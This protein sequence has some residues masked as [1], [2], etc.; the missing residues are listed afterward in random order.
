[1]RTLL[2]YDK[3]TGIVLKEARKIVRRNEEVLNWTKL[4]EKY[5]KLSSMR[6]PV[7]EQIMSS[8]M[9]IIWTYAFWSRSSRFP[10]QYAD[11][12]P[13]SDVV[14][15][16]VQIRNSSKD[17]VSYSSTLFTSQS[18]ISTNVDIQMDDNKENIYPS[19]EIQKDFTSKSEMKAKPKMNLAEHLK[20][21][22]TEYEETEK[23]LKKRRI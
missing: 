7:W 8:M 13:S 5:A 21:A 2:A 9:D 19:D 17:E 11:A 3:A 23:I 18:T 6:L 15:E 12:A 20:R 14:V 4:F 16:P 22:A 10:L 1:M